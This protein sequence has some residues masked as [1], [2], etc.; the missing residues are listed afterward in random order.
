MEG[1]RLGSQTTKDPLFDTAYVW[2]P[3]QEVLELMFYVITSQLGTSLLSCFE[4]LW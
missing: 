4:S 1:L 2:K 3:H